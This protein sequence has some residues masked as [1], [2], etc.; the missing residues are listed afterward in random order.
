MTPRHALAFGILGVVALMLLPVMAPPYYATL[1]IPIFGYAIALLGF[2]LL[3]GYTGLLSFG[4]AMFLGAGAYGAAVMAGVLGIRLFET[5][6][7]AVVLGTMIA[8]LP[9]GFVCVRR[10][11]IF[12]GMLTLAFGMLFYS[13]LFKFYHVT[14]G[15]SGMRVPRMKILG[16]ELTQ[17]NKIELLAGPFYYYCLA[18]LII[19]ALLMWRIVHS[20]FGLHLKAIRDNTRK[21][22]YLGVHVHRCRLAAF[23]ISAGFGAAGGAILGFRIGLAD[24]ELVYWTHSGQLVFMAVL[25]GFSNFFG[26]I[27]GA[28]AYIL[29]QDQ[30]QSLTQYWRFV[31]GAI[32]ALIVIA[33]PGGIA[34]I[35]DLLTR[36]FS[37][38]D[39]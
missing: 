32:L 16:L 30:L 12:F 22:E 7:L 10:V 27:I 23:V 5:M 20:P 8:A 36:R 19:A 18:L 28:F 33:A 39:P 1:M 14:G 2:N 15:D 29:L 24:P 34:G 11:G 21:A 17:Y 9:I 3:F 13:F 31:L 38:A 4:H 26:P 37:R 35:S 25:G 6:L